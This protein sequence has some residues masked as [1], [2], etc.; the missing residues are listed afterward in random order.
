M[1]KPV[2]RRIAAIVA[3][4]G[5]L[6]GI[7]AGAHAQTVRDHRG[8]TRKYEPRPTSG[9]PVVRDHRK[10]VFCFAGPFDPARGTCYNIPYT[11]RPR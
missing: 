4:A 10:P 7:A 2:P 6:L 1:T 5:L 9:T 11:P 8:E 3:A